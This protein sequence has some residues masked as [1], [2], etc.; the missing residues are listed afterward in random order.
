MTSAETGTPPLKGAVK[1][2]EWDYLRSLT[3]SEAMDALDATLGE[4]STKIQEYAFTEEA[5]AKAKPS[6]IAAF[7]RVVQVCLQ[8]TDQAASKFFREKR[9]AEKTAITLEKQMKELTEGTSG[10]RNR[11]AAEAVRLE[12]ETQIAEEQASLRRMTEKFEAAQ[13]QIEDLAREKGTLQQRV[14]QADDKARKAEEN[15]QSVGAHLRHVQTEVERL[16]HLAKSHRKEVANLES[17][18]SGDSKMVMGLSEKVRDLTTDLEGERD[19][20]RR[21]EASCAA[22]VQE[23]KRAAESLRLQV[24][25]LEEDIQQ[26]EAAR[27]QAEAV[28]AEVE[29]R[30]VADMEEL[31]QCHDAMIAQERRTADELREELNTTRHDLMLEQQ[32]ASRT[33]GG[34]ALA[35]LREELK[36]KDQVIG[37]LKEALDD[38]A[39]EAMRAPGGGAGGAGASALTD[40]ERREL[41]SLRTDIVK[42]DRDLDEAGAELLKVQRLLAMYRDKDNSIEKLHADLELTRRACENLEAVN[43]QLNERLGTHD[44]IIDYC[45]NLKA[46]CRKI[47]VTEDELSEINVRGARTEI[48]TL[49]QQVLSLQE[50]I[51]WLERERK[52][53]IQKVRLQPLL[54]T[55]LRLKIG[56]TPE[57]MKIAD[58]IVEN[59]RRGTYVHDAEVENA[60]AD[61]R[62]RYHEEV[63]KRQA[64]EKTFNEVVLSKLEI[65]LNKFLKGHPLLENAPPALPESVVTQLK[66]LVEQATQRGGLGGGGA[67]SADTAELRKAIE[68]Q[69]QLVKS[70]AAR[71]EQLD[72]SLKDRFEDVVEHRRRAARAEEE[73]KITAEERDRFRECLVGRGGDPGSAVAAGA[74]GGLGGSQNLN[75]PLTGSARRGA[76]SPLRPS[77]LRS[78]VDSGVAGRIALGPETAVAIDQLLAIEHGL[79]RQVQTKEVAL[80]ALELRVREAEQR[81][82]EAREQKAASDASVAL[83][84]KEIEAHLR[85]LDDLGSVL[86]ITAARVEELEKTKTDL[87]GSGSDK[88]LLQKIVE[89]RSREAKLLTRVRLLH[90]EKEAAVISHE[91]AEST[92]QERLAALKA[93][94]DSGAD[95]GPCMPHRS[96]KHSSESFLV[97]FVQEALDQLHR[98][99]LLEA[100]R[101]VVREMNAAVAAVT[102]QQAEFTDVAHISGLRAELETTAERLI[103][104]EAE[105]EALR[106]PRSSRGATGPGEEPQ[107]TEERL[108]MLEVDVETWRM[109]CSGLSARL[110][111]KDREVARMEEHLASA[112]ADLKELRGRFAAMSAAGSSANAAAEALNASTATAAAPRAGDARILQHNLI[113][114]YEDEIARLKGT[115]VVLLQSVIDG[116][117]DR[118][119]TEGDLR[120]ATAQLHLLTEQSPP[121]QERAVELVARVMRENSALQHEIVLATSQAKSARLRATAA[122]ANVRILANE[123]GA[124]KLS[125]FRLYNQYVDH[126]VAIAQQC[127][128]VFRQR[129]GALTLRATKEVN[130]RMAALT[131]HV[132]RLEG[133]HKA[134]LGSLAHTEAQVRAAQGDVAIMEAALQHHHA[135]AGAGDAPTTNASSVRRDGGGRLGMP[136]AEKAAE[137]ARNQV[138][139]NLRASNRQLE[140]HKAEAEEECTFLAARVERADNFADNILASLTRLETLGGVMGSPFGSADA[141]AFLTKLGDLRDSVHAKSLAPPIAVDLNRSTMTAG[142]GAAAAAGGAGGSQGSRGARGSVVSLD[143]EETLQQYHDALMNHARLV[144]ERGEL[145]AATE[146]QR[147]QLSVLDARCASLRDELLHAEQRASDSLRQLQDEK[148]KA[149]K[150]EERIAS[151]HQEQ[152]RITAGATEHNVQ[153]LRE[154]IANKER[155]IKQLQQQLESDRARHME[156]ALLDSTRL[157]R[158]H[159]QLHR[160]TASLV[161]RFRQ[162]VDSGRTAGGG[163]D[164]FT[165]DGQTLSTLREALQSAMEREASLQTEVRV[166]RE[167][168]SDLQMLLR[169]NQDAQNRVAAGQAYTEHGRMPAHAPN[170]M[171]SM[172]TST[173]VG[174]AQVDHAAG[175]SASQHPHGISAAINT[176]AAQSMAVAPGPRPAVVPSAHAGIQCDVLA[177]SSP[178]A[179]APPV[180]RL[181]V[182]AGAHSV[183]T[184]SAAGRGAVHAAADRTEAEWIRMR[185]DLEGRDEEVKRLAKALRRAEKELE[186]QK[187]AVPALL[188]IETPAAPLAA[189]A[190]PSA[191]TKPPSVPATAASRAD[192]AAIEAAKADA[193]ELRKRIAKLERDLEQ[194]RTAAATKELAQRRE[195]VEALELQS[196]LE[197]QIGQLTRELQAS[198]RHFSPTPKVTD[199]SMSEPTPQTA[200]PVA[201]G[202][203]GAADVATA[204]T[205]SARISLATGSAAS[206]QH[207]GASAAGPTARTPSPSATAAGRTPGGGA[208]PAR[209]KTLER[210]LGEAN[211]KL[212]AQAMIHRQEVT[213]LVE[214][215]KA[216][217]NQL[218]VARRSPPRSSPAA[219]A[220]AGTTGRKGTATS[221]EAAATEVLLREQLA[222][223]RRELLTAQADVAKAAAKDVEIKRLGSACDE[224]RAKADELTSRLKVSETLRTGQGAATGAIATLRELRHHKA[225]MLHVEKSLDDAK[226]ELHRRTFTAEELQRKLSA[227]ETEI[228]QLR[229]DNASLRAGVTAPSDAKL[230][231]AKGL[232]KRIS[233]LEDLV[234]TKDG[235]LLDLRFERETLQ[236]R[237]GRLERHLDEMVS[238]DR[239]EQQQ[240]HASPSPTGRQLAPGLNGGATP[241]GSA[242]APGSGAA[243]TAARGG[244]S[245]TDI[246][247]IAQLEGVVENMKAVIERLHKENTLLKTTGVSGSRY[248]EATRELKHLRGRERE[249]IETIQQLNLKLAHA[250]ASRADPVALAQN[251][252]AYGDHAAMLQRRLRL[253]EASND[254]LKSEN[255]QLKVIVRPL[256]D[257][258]N[259]AIGGFGKL[260]EPASPPASTAGAT[261]GAYGAEER[262]EVRYGVTGLYG[263]AA[264][265][266]SR[267][268]ARFPELLQPEH[269]EHRLHYGR[270]EASQFPS[271]SPLMASPAVPPGAPMSSSTAFASRREL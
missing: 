247:R 261:G 203:H 63:R 188:K 99:E 124:Y 113:R 163:A 147:Q 92:I 249:L 93:A 140:R 169:Q 118:R 182:P 67:S 71:L 162:S 81:A 187:K 209:L 189:T 109:R 207:T 126:A 232:Q 135:A 168:T 97:H 146:T 8:K 270:D 20:A 137:A 264:T 104:V 85:N 26:A 262:N 46:L 24:V 181:P 11:K 216:L 78:S 1:P 9:Q 176:S 185:S 143:E 31:R 267:D 27:E 53:W 68:E 79:R 106:A 191:S 145:L 227:T 225:E 60:N 86:E 153:C 133:I 49:R 237:A 107:S 138:L 196:T 155:V 40:K 36:K 234:L 218:V 205:S 52:H 7:C 223:T 22:Q 156:N 122:E 115:N 77:Q 238:T 105:L 57:Q 89:L 150:R 208:D 62:E 4:A 239:R 19:R 152:R 149:S 13:R 64:D 252:Q 256:A 88:R 17:Q 33:D 114:A 154:V 193:K 28:V 16:Q 221:A 260:L 3:L 235:M 219:A 134:T 96:S 87:M 172:G 55:N 161:E 164:A 58:E 197:R 266:A 80:H 263:D 226:L 217:E 65:G 213:K 123:A 199:T 175:S 157:E 258:T 117:A 160:E 220:G 246:T 56:L 47:G 173:P 265:A 102:Q 32:L 233:E 141:D 41:L 76:P 50:E 244:H 174:P 75:S 70:Q 73:A 183:T 72:L 159:D 179:G 127:R 195:T 250:Q 35:A 95:A 212:A 111:D 120:A 18:S 254:R 257:R 37:Q 61:F 23:A 103:A 69:T 253:A 29:R 245:A 198:K 129:D 177:A 180:P 211:A 112:R 200:P 268:I 271:S 128:A 44:D 10:G 210:Q 66:E 151:A 121:L 228:E 130:Q 5:I 194:E 42:M 148:A 204:G 34:S 6:D 192:A 178:T 101:E 48:E 21:V 230:A 12:L 255:E 269:W 14:E 136:P 98:G 51:E 236:L 54:E 202:A 248:V 132:L 224:W 90:R 259:T 170:L 84:E 167:R 166:L 186:R 190:P 91:R 59:M 184:A 94:F 131:H 139:A 158:L 2:V 45:E 116:H 83:K 201:A 165:V 82:A 229:A 243:A 206:P 231:A 142:G 241:R 39:Q 25:T 242:G 240:Q 125:A 251:R 222:T 214:D 119:R 215:K 108:A 171:A 15:A 100:D 144:K 43:E 38:A 74:A 30:A 110:S